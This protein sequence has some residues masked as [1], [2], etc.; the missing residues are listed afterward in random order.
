MNNRKSCI[1]SWHEKSTSVPVSLLFFFSP[2]SNPPKTMLH[3]ALLKT[4]HM[5]SRKKIHAIAKAAKTLSCAVV[6]KTGRPPGV[7]IAE[8]E[9]RNENQDVDGK[10]DNGQ[11]RIAGGGEERLR[12]WVSAVKVCWWKLLFVSVV[13]NTNNFSWTA[14]S[15]NLSVPKKT[16]L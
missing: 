8:C 16:L 2:L 13:N 14:I 12:E 6:L 15:G 10:G 11:K 5:T 9:H 1:P 3:R 7:M 4:H